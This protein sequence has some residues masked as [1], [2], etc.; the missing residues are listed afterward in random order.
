MYAAQ[1][2]RVMAACTVEYNNNCEC[3]DALLESRQ[4]M[5]SQYLSCV[6][7]SLQQQV[8]QGR[9]AVRRMGSRHEKHEKLHKLGAMDLQH[10]TLK[11]VLQSSP[12]L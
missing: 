2:L 6:G 11:G 10:R 4:C 1:A 9:Y 3:A 7:Q 8:Q 5:S 12:R